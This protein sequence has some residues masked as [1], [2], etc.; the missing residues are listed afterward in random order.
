MM[1]VS[2]TASADELASRTLELCQSRAT[3][4][5]GL[6]DEFK[7]RGWLPVDGASRDRTLAVLGDGMIIA[8]LEYDSSPDWPAQIRDTAELMDRFPVGPSDNLTL[9]AAQM[10]GKDAAL[11]VIQLDHLP[12]KPLRCVYSGP[13]DPALTSM[14]NGIVAM[15]RRVGIA[16]S[17]PSFEMVT[18][19]S[20]EPTAPPKRGT[21]FVSSQIAR[22]TATPRELGR[23]PLAEIA[24]S[25]NSASL[26]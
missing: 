16:H 20:A 4:T 2:A 15:D 17:D 26:E 22:Y 18:I 3:Y 6:V 11:L 12:Q 13:S 9:F 8:T 25:V 14:V 23:A 5:P 19:Q 7:S 24:F 1:F 10:G 21:Q